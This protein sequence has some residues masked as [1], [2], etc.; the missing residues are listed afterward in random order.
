MKTLKN[1]C[2]ALFLVIGFSNIAQAASAEI[3][4]AGTDDAGQR[5]MLQ[6]KP[7]LSD[8]GYIQGDL[9]SKTASGVK[10]IIQKAFLG[11]ADG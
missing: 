10:T 11:D 4:C 2:C 3:L 8:L 9:R 7:A 6:M 5:F 1:V